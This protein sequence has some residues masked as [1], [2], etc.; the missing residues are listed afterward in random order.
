ML[1]DRVQEMTPLEEYATILHVECLGALIP[2]EHS[3]VFFKRC[4]GPLKKW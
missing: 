1:F 2:Q 3:F 4:E